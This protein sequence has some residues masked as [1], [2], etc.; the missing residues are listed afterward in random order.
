MVDKAYHDLIAKRL[1]L[2]ER[3]LKANIDSCKLERINDLLHDVMLVVKPLDEQ[4][5]EGG[6]VLYTKIVDSTKDAA[7]KQELLDETQRKFLHLRKKGRLGISGKANFAWAQSNVLPLAPQRLPLTIQEQSASPVDDV[8]NDQAEDTVAQF[9]GGECI[10]L[11]EWVQCVTCSKWRKLPS[12][13]DSK[14]L[15]EDWTCDLGGNLPPGFNCHVAEDTSDAN[16]ECK[17]VADCHQPLNGRHRV[18]RVGVTLH[19]EEERIL[20]LDW[21]LRPC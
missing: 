19:H 2:E 16:E 17:E 12:A 11:Q 8:T 5:I 1:E 3:S 14:S 18:K 7:K 20:S 9:E 6:S 13:G 10:E 21:G 4:N 15:P